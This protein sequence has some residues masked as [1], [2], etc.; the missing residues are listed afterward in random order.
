MKN[1]TKEQENHEERP[2]GGETTGRRATAAEN[3]R[4]LGGNLRRVCEVERQIEGWR[5]R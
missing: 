5:T 1:M 2:Q 4:E 3:E